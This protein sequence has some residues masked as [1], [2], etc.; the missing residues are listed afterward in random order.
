MRRIDRHL[1]ASVVSMRASMNMRERTLFLYI[2]LK[3]REVKQVN[4][5]RCENKEAAK[6]NERV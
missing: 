1:V 5:G 2:D 6:V 4:E 3:K